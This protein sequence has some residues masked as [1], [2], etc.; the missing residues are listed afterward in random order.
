LTTPSN[1]IQ[2]G[3]YEVT[4]ISLASTAGTPRKPP[5]G[6]GVLCDPGWVLAGDE[7]E[8]DF[9]ISYTQRDRPWAEWIAWELEEA[10]HRVLIQAWDFVGG[11]N[12]VRGMQQGVSRAERTLAVLSPAYLES[13]YG[14]AEWQA[15]WRDDPTGEQRKLLVVRVAD[16]PRPGLL[17]SVVG[18]D[19]FGVSEAIA[20]QRLH[21]L[22]RGAIEGR[23][24]PSDR[25][26]FPPSSRAISG[27]RPF[28]EG[29]PSVWNVPAR[30]PNFTGRADLLAE[31]D[32]ALGAGATVTVSAVRGMG[33]VGKTQLAIEYAHQNAARYDVV[34]WIAA[35]EAATIPDQF[36]ALAEQ[37]GV[38][39]GGDPLILRAAVHSP[40]RQ[41][42][43]WLLIFDN[44]D[45]ADDVR[46]WIPTSPQRPG[47]PGHVLITTRRGG[48]RP[49]GRV[50]DIDVLDIEAAVELM[51]TRAPD[52]EQDDAEAIAEFLGRLPLALTQAAAYL[53]A[54]GMSTAEY[55]KLLQMRTADMLRRG[56]VAERADATVATLWKLSL[57]RVAALRPAAA[58]LLDICAY[59]APDAIPLDLFTNHTDLLPEPLAG[60]AMDPLEFSDLL[61]VLVD[62]SLVKR[63][64]EELQL[65]RLVQAA[66]RARH[67]VPP[68]ESE[69][70][71]WS[72]LE[73][74]LH[75]LEA[76]V[77]RRIAEVPENW[78]RWAVLLPHVLAA[79][80][81]HADSS[82][83][84]SSDVA[85]S[86][87]LDR[88]GSYLRV[89]GRPHAARPLLER[90]LRIDE[91]VHGPEH[92]DVGIALGNLALVLRDLGDLVG[93]RPLLERALGITEAAYGPEHPEVGVR[94]G[95]LA[96]VLG[97]MGDPAAAQPLLERALAIAET[98]YGP[99]HPTVGL[100]LGNLAMLL[101]DLGELAA[102]RLMLERAM[103]ITEAAYG[104]EHPDVGAHLSN[105]AVVLWDLGDLA[106]A[107]P[108]A[109]RALAITEAAYEPEHPTIGIA[110]GNLAAILRA[111]GDPAA[112]RP[113]AERA[114]AIRGR[115][116]GTA[117]G[118]A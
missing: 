88:A 3:A 109:E 42:N 14:E 77:P 118:P 10:G 67:A 116:R 43:G 31:L 89:H 66:I 20:K 41:V 1:S 83:V 6:A 85:A 62:Y 87:L 58:Q 46:G 5:F 96:V 100:R 36:T 82:V 27:P 44:V 70:M 108:L 103:S 94:L 18:E 33:G 86:W 101:R 111:L 114:Q 53:D 97:D 59:L 34:W 115:A 49:L 30:N 60:E 45:S 68:A 74:A 23:L 113:L 26:A 98:A 57:H 16:C 63:S 92:P 51:R 9:F 112:A 102:A 81:F 21:R 73:A 107:R 75:L 69:S 15:A 61:G 39:A 117:E 65:H 17:G 76:D 91:A 8:A 29:L 106:A 12:W 13:V 25:P 47:I 55:L 93:A 78:P 52:I 40:L 72:P 24:K 37:L 104:P 48:F 80:G 64:R 56:E 19:L 22:V 38:E 35:E 105:L 71:E 50:L 90:A 4:A 2:F 11:S 79:T 99:E 84:Q 95:N 7:P 32:Q 110:L 54:T 28:P